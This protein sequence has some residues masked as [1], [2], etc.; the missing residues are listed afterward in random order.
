[1]N[2]RAV[3]LDRDGVINSMVY[4]KDHGIVDS[5]FTCRQFKVLPGVKRAIK[6][7]KGMGMKA[8][9]VSNQPGMAKG[10]YSC[11]EL[12][13]ID[14]KMCATLK[15]SISLDGVYYCLHHP[16]AKFSKY[17]KNCSCRKPKP[18]LILKAAKE[19]GIDLSRSYMI[20]DGVSDIEA[21]SRAGCKTIL[22]GRIKCDICSV[23]SARDIRP[24]AVANGLLDAVLKIKKWE[25]A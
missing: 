4:Y 2:N 8:I 24:D 5:P 16:Q 15:G 18:G 17:R 25:G 3:F 19:Q 23:M 10:H 13:A 1:M 21:G 7:I 11:V 14:K 12:Q 20:G 9:V 22:L 6:L